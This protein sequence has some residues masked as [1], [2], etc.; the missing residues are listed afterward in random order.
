M[1][2]YQNHFLVNGD[3]VAEFHEY[4]SENQLI[5]TYRYVE[6]VIKKTEE[7]LEYEED[8]PPADA[9]VLFARVMKFDFI[10][11]YFAEEPVVIV[12]AESET[13]ETEGK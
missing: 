10:D 12:P 3:I 6:P 7:Q 4:D 2:W 11:Y 5:M 9:T 8:N 13:D 1:Q